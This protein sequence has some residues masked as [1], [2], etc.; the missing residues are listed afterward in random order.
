MTD[1][2]FTLIKSMETV[3]NIQALTP[4]KQREERKRRQKPHKEQ[5]ETGEKPLN[6]TARE[7]AHDEGDGRHQIDYRA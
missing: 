4:D 6:E 1:S 5:P 7:Q 2:D 3:H